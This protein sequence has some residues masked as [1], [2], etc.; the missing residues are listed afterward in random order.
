MALALCSGDMVG[1]YHVY[2]CSR[3]TKIACSLTVQ[4]SFEVKVL[5]PG[6]GRGNLSTRLVFTGERWDALELCVHGQQLKWHCAEC[7]VYRRLQEGRE[8][9]RQQKK[10]E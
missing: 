1:A 10:P 3:Q 9:V 6:S 4:M 5:E 7:D 2:S 8:R